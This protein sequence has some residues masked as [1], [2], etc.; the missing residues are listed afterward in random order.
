M[1]TKPVRLGS[2]EIGSKTFVI[3]AGPCAVEDESSFQSTGAFLKKEGVFGLRGGV[4]K[5]RT[6]FESFQG[7]GQEALSFIKKIKTDLNLFFI[8]EITDPRQRES[9]EEVVDIFQV[10]TRNMFNYELLKELGR[11]TKKPVLLK[12]GFSARIEEWVQAAEYLIQSGNDQVILCERGIRTFETATR[13]TLDLSAV[14]YLKEKTSFPVI[15]D[16]SHG[17]GVSSF[18][19]SLA[20][21]ALAVG[22]DGLLLEVHPRPERALSDGKQ[23]LTFEAFSHLMKEL[24]EM[25]PFFSR[26][27]Y[28]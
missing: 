11:N 1:K 4:Y 15:V 23:A 25:M 2:Q 19:P 26:E 6:Q 14:V 13:N 8:T 22:A 10:G 5:L 20:K 24:R 12:R 27:F 7:L 17:V 16:P 21:G 9:L 18:V 28:R 3:F